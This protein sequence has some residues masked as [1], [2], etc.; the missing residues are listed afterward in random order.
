MSPWRR[1]PRPV[2][3]ALSP[4]S[5]VWQPETVLAEVQQVWFDAVGETIA[6]ESEPVAE[7]GGVVTISCSSSLWAHELNLLA[8]PILE[9]LNA[10]IRGGPVSRLRCVAG[11]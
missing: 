11:S 8:P 2:G 10:G 3:A 1:A 9:R 5:R 6:R 7:R 4:L